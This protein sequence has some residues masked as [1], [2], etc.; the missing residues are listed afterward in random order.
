[1]LPETPIWS[2]TSSSSEAL[3]LELQHGLEEVRDPFL[4][5]TVDS[6]SKSVTGSLL[7]EVPSH[8]KR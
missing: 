6:G 5:A 3:G 1:M 8:G 4:A 7:T 2:L